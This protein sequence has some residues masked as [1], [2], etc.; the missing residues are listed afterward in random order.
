MKMTGSAGYAVE[1]LVRMREIAAR[2]EARQRRRLR[3]HGLRED[4]L[5][6]VAAAR[7]GHANAD[8]FSPLGHGVGHHT[9]D[10][11]EARAVRPDRVKA[12]GQNARGGWKSEVVFERSGLCQHGGSSACSR[13]WLGDG[14]HSG[15][16][17]RAAT[18]RDGCA[19][20]RK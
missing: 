14:G 19:V 20:R 16:R 15:A 4:E 5:H 9:V 18:G 3:A 6:D 1:R 7:H 11:E 12:N 10:S 17:G 13:E 8:F 2:G